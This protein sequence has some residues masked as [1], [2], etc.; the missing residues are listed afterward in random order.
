M[1]KQLNL[2]G[3]PVEP[4][5]DEP[6]VAVL[7]SALQKSIRRGWTEK[8]MAFS[9]QL[10][11]RAGWYVTWR[12]L[13][14]IAM[15]DVGQPEVIN[16]VE[17]LYRLFMEF[18]GK[19]NGELSWDAK[20]TVVLAALIMAESRKD[21]RAD[22]FLELWAVMEKRK[23]VEAL[24]NLKAYWTHIPDEA[25]DVHTAEGRKMGRGNEYWYSVSSKCE[26]MSP[27]YAKWREVWENLMLTL[28]KMKKE[29]SGKLLN[30]TLTPEKEG[31]S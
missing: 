1:E 20:R 18:K 3:E 16:A 27:E 10:L 6:T 19:K 22:E 13:R 2:H 8:A 23:D 7:K 14:I 29:K 31:E 21:R 5:E 30:N 17:N 26:N 24:Q 9:L 4:E 12:R 28:C 15:E 11:E 25:Y